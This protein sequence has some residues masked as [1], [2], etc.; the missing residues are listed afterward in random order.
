M[1]G[2]LRELRESRHLTQTGIGLRIGAS[3]QNISKYEQ[4]MYSI[5]IDMLIRIADYFNVTT[6]YLLGI[7][8]VK[9]YFE[10]QIQLNKSMVE[11]YEIVEMYRN[12]DNRDRE[13]IWAMMEKMTKLNEG[14]H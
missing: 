9:R 3:Q 8:E 11:H 10:K 4:D 1:K 5:P 2:K 14:R 12:L 7:S 6:D 13:I